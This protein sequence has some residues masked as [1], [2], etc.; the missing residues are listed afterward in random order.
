MK[1]L[2][3]DYYALREAVERSD[4]PIDDFLWLAEKA[5]IMLAVE[6]HNWPIEWGDESDWGGISD[7]AGGTSI[8]IEEP[9]KP[10]SGYYNHGYI[11]ILWSEIRSLRA[12][13][14]LSLT[15]VTAEKDGRKYYGGII[16]G[17]PDFLHR[18]HECDLE[19][20]DV[21]IS[22]EELQRVITCEAGEWETEKEPALMDINVTDRIAEKPTE[23]RNARIKREFRRLYKQNPNHSSN[24][25]IIAKN[26]DLNP[27]E[28]SWTTIIRIRYLK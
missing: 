8:E 11:N 15:M 18:Q 9:I 3:K 21:F 16:R 19:L 4:L 2:K 23:A 7:I 24:A 13:G 1:R 22:H 20:K 17:L 10:P 14:I 28:R 5:H 6:A 27:E 25:K 12:N 26:P